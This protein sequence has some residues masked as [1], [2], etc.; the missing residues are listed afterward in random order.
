MLL[1]KKDMGGAANVLGL[2][3]MI[4]AA[5]L[6]GAA[7]RADPGGRERDFRQCLPAGRRA[8]AA[9]RA[10]PSRSATPTPKAG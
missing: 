1:M 6:H 5:R 8:D 9:A 4:M 2:A 7:A 10:S 3:Q